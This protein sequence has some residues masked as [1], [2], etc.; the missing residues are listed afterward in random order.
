MESMSDDANADAGS[1]GNTSA[2]AA[3]PDAAATVS[4]D[5]LGKTYASDR[6]TVEALSDVE[7]AVEDGEFV[8]IVGPSGCGKTTLFR[9]IAGLE[10][11]TSGAV[12]L[13]GSPVTGPGTDRGMVFQEYG[14]FPWRTVSENVAFG[15]E[16]QGVEEPARSERVTEML[17]LVGLDG[18]V[19]A[20]P[21]ELSGG[22]KQRVGI[23]RALAVDPELLLMDEP[24]GAVDAQTRDMLHGELLDIW[25][26]TD[27]TVLFVT[28]DVEEAV[29]LA[30]RVVVMAANPG[31]VR[32]IVSVDIDRPRERTESEFAAYVERIRGLIG[33]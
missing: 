1:D 32:E 17:E 14:L 5:S 25:T 4:V 11:A 27:K 31:R 26:E 21:K 29:T 22:M 28:H 10:D 20:Y 3:D 30:D 8:C 7:F 16:E 19:D 9:I 33:E 12:T 23:A 6:R 24:F 18:F 2:T 13:D 15:L